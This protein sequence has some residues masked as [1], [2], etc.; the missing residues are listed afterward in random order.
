MVMTVKTTTN[1]Q[2]H[3]LK[4]CMVNPLVKLDFNTALFFFGYGN[5]VWYGITSLFYKSTLNFYNLKIPRWSRFFLQSIRGWRVG[6]NN[7]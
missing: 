1:K 7:L 4:P 2:R 6:N 3:R 5:I